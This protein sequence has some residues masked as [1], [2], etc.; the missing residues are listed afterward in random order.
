MS[1]R[2]ASTEQLPGLAERALPL[3]PFEIALLADDPAIDE[4]RDVSGKLASNPARGKQL[5]SRQT[6]VGL[7][8]LQRLLGVHEITAGPLQAR[9]NLFR[10]A[11]RRTIT[12]TDGDED[13]E[14]L[15]DHLLDEVHWI[16]HV[17]GWSEKEIL[18]LPRW[19]RHAYCERI[20]KLKVEENKRWKAIAGRR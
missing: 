14:T 9:E 12:A 11:I 1:P 3:R 18:N 19:K 17:Y 7:D 5:G 20:N 15:K 13:R 10:V 8:Q 4:D 2:R 6:R 16:A